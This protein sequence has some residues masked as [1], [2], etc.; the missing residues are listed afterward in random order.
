MDK[1]KMLLAL[2]DK[3]EKQKLGLVFLILL[4]IGFIELAGI[5]SLGPFISVVSNPKG[6][7][8]N[9]YLSKIYRLFNFSSDPE[10]ITALG[11]ASIFLIVISNISLLGANFLIY[12]YSAKRMHTLSIRLFERYLRQ[13]YIFYLNRST[14]ELSTHI[15]VDVYSFIHGVLLNLLQFISSIIIA[16]CI[17]GMLILLN[18]VLALIASGLIGFSYIIIFSFVKNSLA[19]KG[20]ETNAQNFLKSKYISESFLGIKDIKILGKEKVFLNCFAEPSK[21]SATNEVYLK[22]VGDMPKYL[23]EMIA[24]GGVIGVIVVMIHFGSIIDDFL[25]ILAVYLFGA[26]RLLP[27][28]Q[29]IFQTFT[30]IKFNFPAVRNLYADFKELPVGYPLPDGDVVRMD[31]HTQ[32]R[33]ESIVF[34]YPSSGR[35]IIKDQSLVIEA[36]TSVAFVGATGCGKT[37]LV[38]IML[39]LLEPQRGKLWVDDVEITAENKRNWQKNLGYIPQANFLTNDT[40]QNNIAF[41]VESKLVDKQAVIRAAKLANLHDFIVTELKEGYDTVIGER[42]IRLSGGQRQR[43][44]IARAVY[45]DPSVLIL[46]E[47]TSALDSITENAIIEAIKNLSG[48][49]TIVMIAHRITTV[50]NC[51]IIYLMDKGIIADKGTYTELYQKNAVFKKMADGV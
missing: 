24:I 29:R 43:I 7:H 12:S 17:I 11:L 35:D 1:I 38:D 44:G 34:R 36:N 28:L 41:G 49:K 23:I 26:Y 45:H 5:G 37:T 46:D 14:T 20:K 4:F 27:L 3:R 48:K 9:R 31:F 42:G 15:S 40:I 50:K 18:P 47:A 10:F 32:I 25:P 6:I 51:D 21:K 33:L 13:P 19:R 8:T 39:G 30:S 2:F 22:T 16:L